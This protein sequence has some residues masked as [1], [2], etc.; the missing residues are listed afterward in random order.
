M[1]DDL[2]DRLLDISPGPSWELAKLGLEAAH[3]IQ[4]LEE[5]I[6]TALARYV[7]LDDTEALHAMVDILRNALKKNP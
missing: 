6:R 5:S 2:T 7:E 4:F 3:R 1:N